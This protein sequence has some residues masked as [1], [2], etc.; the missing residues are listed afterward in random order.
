MQDRVAISAQ[1]AGTTRRTR[2]AR[3]SR[4]AHH[5]GT[6]TGGVNDPHFRRG[7]ASRA[8]QGGRSRHASLCVDVSAP[9]AGGIE[10]HPKLEAP[11][12]A[13]PAGTMAWLTAVGRGS[14][15]PSAFHTFRCLGNCRG[16]VCADLVAPSAASSLN[17]RWVNS[18]A[19]AFA[20]RSGHRLRGV[21]DPRDGSGTPKALQ[22]GGRS[23]PHC[24][25]NPATSGGTTC[26]P[27]AGRAVEPRPATCRCSGSKSD[28]NGAHSQLRD[29]QHS[30]SAEPP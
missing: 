20:G 26:R 5:A 29:T 18:Q 19:P 8:S 2:R 9:P 7:A 15:T 6:R 22:E 11:A 30:H 17:Q 25:N 14:E 4:G 23:R 3:S 24:D 10:R 13:F 21:S 28:A 12:L 16:Q 27:I 1:I